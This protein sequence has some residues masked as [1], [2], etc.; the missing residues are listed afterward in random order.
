MG[1]DGGRGDKPNVAVAVEG[2]GAKGGRPEL[3][4][5]PEEE[6]RRDASKLLS[7]WEKGAAGAPEAAV[8]EGA[9]DTGAP[10][11]FSNRVAAAAATIGLI[12]VSS[13]ELRRELEM[14]GGVGA[15]ADGRPARLERLLVR[16]VPVRELTADTIC[17][18]CC[19][20]LR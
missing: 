13:R 5:A 1:A 20:S 6:R 9:G 14:T 11:V 7:D 10:N 12:A 4:P 8:G 16:G 19:A 2:E 17:P 18:F 15:P 3:S